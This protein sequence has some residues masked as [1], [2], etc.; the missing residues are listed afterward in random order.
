M[1]IIHS[2]E[3]EKVQQNCGSND[4]FRAEAKGI[5]EITTPV[6]MC[7]CDI[8]ISAYKRGFD[9]GIARAKEYKGRAE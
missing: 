2:K 1:D 4:G 5:A 9:G 6:I 8:C 3:W 7:H